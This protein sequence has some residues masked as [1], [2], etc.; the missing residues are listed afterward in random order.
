[1]QWTNSGPDCSFRG[2]WNEGGPLF[3][4]I[5]QNGR[6]VE[7]GLLISGQQFQRVVTLMGI[8]RAAELKLAPWRCLDE[9]RDA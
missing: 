5:P 3:S 8:P 1:M 4:Q 2:E 6:W 7:V 9:H